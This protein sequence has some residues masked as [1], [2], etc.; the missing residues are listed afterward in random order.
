M[1]IADFGSGPRLFRA[2]EGTQ[3][4]DA[5]VARFDGSVWTSI[6][7]LAQGAIGFVRV[8][9]LAAHDD[10]GGPALYAGGTFASANGVPAT[11]VARWDPALGTWSAVGAGLDNSVYALASHAGPSGPSLWAGGL[12]AQNLSVFDGSTWSVP[13]GGANGIVRVFAIADEGDGPALFAG[14]EFTQI[15]GVAASLVTRRQGSTWVPLGAGLSLPGS[16]FAWVTALVD[17]EGGA[18]GQKGLFAGGRFTRAAETASRLVA[19]WRGCPGPIDEFC[20]GDGTL[21]TCPCGN[22]GVGDRGCQNSLSTGGAHLASS[23]ATNPDTLLL[24]ATGEMPSAITIFLQ[25][26]TRIPSGTSFGDGLRC[27]G[28]ALKR[29]YVKV[30]SSG[31]VSAP[32]ASDPSISARSAALGDPIAPGTLRYYQTY[33]R[34]AAPNFCPAPT[35]STFNASSGVRVAW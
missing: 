13:A 32:G 4:L 22:N 35:G 9:A 12:F 19:R 33:Y 18:T 25:G 21:V 1:T 15:G 20:P 14:G 17:H 10:G 24:Q 31:A 26:N 28:G 29:L 6:G 7:S 3:A 27:V 2:N 11:N 5:N 34:D 23:G 30:A 16:P 8:T